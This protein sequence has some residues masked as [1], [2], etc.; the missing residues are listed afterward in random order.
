MN[1]KTYFGDWRHCSRS[2][3]SGR[4]NYQ[5]KLSM[6]V[7]TWHAVPRAP[8]QKATSGSNVRTV[9]FGCVTEMDASRCSSFTSVTFARKVA[10]G[11]H[12]HEICC[13]WM[14]RNGEIVKRMSRQNVKQVKRPKQLFLWMKNHVL[15]RIWD[16]H[17]NI[18]SIT[19]KDW[20]WWLK[21]WFWRAFAEGPIRVEIKT[22]HYGFTWK[23]STSGYKSSRKEPERDLKRC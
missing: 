6:F 11:E 1:L 22:E 13:G 2:E 7:R 18:N 3:L 16:F 5:R 12:E 8:R 20:V 19:S 9:T 17:V 23:R 21:D 15:K 14:N 4:E 10:L